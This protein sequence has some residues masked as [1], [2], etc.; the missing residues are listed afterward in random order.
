MN[1]NSKTRHLLICAALAFY[2]LMIFLLYSV[3]NASLQ[4]HGYSISDVFNFVHTENG[5]I[6]FGLIIPPDIYY[7][8][9]LGSLFMIGAVAFVTVF[10]FSKGIVII[11]KLSKNKE[12]S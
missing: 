1:T 8:A 10:I 3:F 6:T 9:L 4:D 12:L 5:V 7:D 11:D 2:G